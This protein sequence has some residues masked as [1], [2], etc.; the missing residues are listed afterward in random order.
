MERT[1]NPDLL[2]A[3]LEGSSVLPTADELARLMVLAE[4]NGLM[5]EGQQPANPDLLESA[6][7]YFLGAASSPQAEEYYPAGLR[8]Q[9]FQVAA[10]LLDLTLRAAGADPI[11]R[12]ARLCFAAQVAYLR[13]FQQ[14]NAAALYR[15]AFPNGQPWESVLTDQVLTCLHFGTLFL[16]SDLRTLRQDL[17]LAQRELRHLRERWGIDDLTP[18]WF[19]AT[20]N[21]VQGVQEL[22]RFQ[23]TGN[24]NVLQMSRSRF[25]QAVT[26]SRGEPI[27]RWVASLLLDLSDDLEGSSPWTVLPPDTPPHVVQAFTQGQPPILTLWPPQMDFLRA[28]VE[29]L[30]ALDARRQF[31]AAPTSAG[32]TLIAQLLVALQLGRGGRGACVVVPTRSLSG[33]VTRSLRA[34]LG[35][36]ARVVESDLLTADL[37]DVQ[38]DE[39]DRPTF[40]IS[41]VTP[42]KLSDLLHRDTQAVLNRYDLFIF[43]EVHNVNNGSRGWLL[44][45]LITYLHVMTR[46]TPHRLMLMSAA[47]GN[48]Q[49]F[50]QWL[51]IDGEEPFARASGGSDPWRAPRRLTA[52]YRTV[53]AELLSQRPIGKGP[54]ERKEY[55][56][57]GQLSAPLFDR[58]G[59][60]LTLDD[61]GRLVLRSTGQR[62]RRMSGASTPQ[63]ETVVP[64]VDSL[65]RLGLV[66]AVIQHRQ[67]VQDF[68]VKLARVRTPVQ[69]TPQL[70]GLMDEVR[71]TLGDTHPLLTTLL[72]GVA[73][74]HGEL[75]HDLRLNLER[76]AA[77]G[78]IGCLVCTTSLTEGINLPVHSVVIVETFR[79]AEGGAVASF[80]PSQILNALGRAGRAAL[81]TEGILVLV[82]HRGESDAVMLQMAQPQPDQLQVHS[83]LAEHDVIEA[84]VRLERQLEEDE[85]ALFHVG[86]DRAREFVTFVWW[87]AAERDGRTEAVLDVVRSSFAAQ[88]RQ[89]SSPDLESVEQLVQR[90][91]SVYAR[92]PDQDRRRWAKASTSLGT[93]RRMDAWAA[94]LLADPFLDFLTGVELLNQLLELLLPEFLTTPE[95]QRVMKDQW[96]EWPHKLLVLAWVSGD[97]LN[98]IAERTSARGVTLADL[99]RYM[100]GFV[101]FTLPWLMS[102]VLER[103]AA[104]DEW[105]LISDEEIATVTA[106]LRYGVPHAAMLPPVRDGRLS[107][108]LAVRLW[109]AVGNEA[110]TVAEIKTWL[111][112][113]EL[114]DW[115]TVLDLTS[116][117][118]DALIDFVG[119]GL[120]IEEGELEEW[121]RVKIPDLDTTQAWAVHTQE[122][123]GIRVIGLMQQ[124]HVKWVATDQQA[125]VRQAIDRGFEFANRGGEDREVWLVSRDDSVIDAYI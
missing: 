81:E 114:T 55:R 57:R 35:R 95:V 7:W 110:A 51:S 49:H 122:V 70:Q 118:L 6:G 119:V 1:V 101:E 117:E 74:H 32:K 75:P 15:K 52:V 40:L 96:Q 85:A 106:M 86:H 4:L 36:L 104:F 125:A 30:F 71:R 98:G 23:K 33:E 19:G 37:E 112:E 72:R 84:F 56:L 115:P 41:V 21:V 14:P 26:A 79:H 73:F 47:V 88:A 69:V 121:A 46:E 102:A 94:L 45:S 31:L 124:G 83:V 50:L 13:G 67:R 64:L 28:S 93:S 9:A 22:V 38:A 3:L 54:D 62:Q 76:A 91:L 107:R 92:T 111:R 43:D 99:Q 82:A 60:E 109:H 29:Q 59:Q 10:H 89:L 48:D 8:R 18:T 90:V 44:E 105:W 53:P 80:T 77:T 103:V 12:R 78:E 58:V 61:V 66:M 42:E 116:F 63:Y 65:M 100:Y 17:R 16:A 39:P 20:A 97:S 24:T 120:V 34:R 2:S 68:A 123:L 113:R 5:T 108:N 27:C 87:I 25:L 11:V